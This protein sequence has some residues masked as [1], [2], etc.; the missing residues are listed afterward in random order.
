MQFKKICVSLLLLNIFVGFV[1]KSEFS[2]AWQYEKIKKIDIHKKTTRS[3]PTD[4]WAMHLALDVDPEDLA[5]KKGLEYIRP[6]GPLDGFY[7]FRVS[8]KK[9]RVF[10]A[11]NLQNLPEVLWLEQQKK[12]WRFARLPLDPL[13]PKQWHLHN[14]GQFQEEIGV[15]ISVLPVWDDGFQGDGVQIAIVDDGLQYSHPDIQRNFVA[16]DSWDFIDNDPD[17]SP[18]LP[19]NAHGTSVAGLA[20]ARDDGT[21]CGLGSAYRASITG[22]RLIAEPITDAMEAQ[23]LTYHYQNNQIFNSSWG[24]ADDGQ[25][26]E[27]P[28]P[29]TRLALEDGVNKGRGGLGSIYVWAGGNGQVNNDNLNYD[30]YANSRYTIAVGAVDYFGLQTG[31]SEPGAPMLITVPSS[32]SG[33]GICTTDLMAPNGYESSANCTTNFGGTSSS[34]PLVSGI[35]SL[36]LQAN[37]DLTWIDIQR[38]LIRSTV[39]NDPDDEDWMQNGAGRWVNHKYGFGLIDAELAVNLARTWKGSGGSMYCDSKVITVNQEIPDNDLAGIT[40][41]VNITQN[42]KVEHVQVVFSATHTYRGDLE[43]TLTSPDGTPSILAQKHAD[44]NSDY[45][46]WAFL[47]VRHWG[48]SSRGVWTLRVADVW[49]MD[50]GTFDSWQLILHGTEGEDGTGGFLPGVYLLLEEE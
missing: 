32:G 13:F 28:G 31:Y 43:I 33:T 3:V 11:K 50:A 8:E 48:E 4:T 42:F 34:A 14:T 18:S 17:P 35:I 22:I 26:L 47:S 23:A 6:I 2:M 16:A 45:P 38:I 39:K 29:L 36:M 27:G 41:T 24:P 25:R 37:P 9:A 20:A 1:I 12:R 10:D 49:E 21:S 46:G 5:Q 44:E 15:D 30:G 40:S 7:L 19:E